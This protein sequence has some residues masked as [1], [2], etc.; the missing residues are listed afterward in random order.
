MWVL[1]PNGVT[2]SHT[3]VKSSRF[4]G[5]LS[6]M[7]MFPLG[8]AA[9][10]ATS[11]KHIMPSFPSPEIDWCRVLAAGLYCRSAGCS[12]AVTAAATRVTATAVSKPATGAASKADPAGPADLIRQLNL[13][14][15]QGQV[16]VQQWGDKQVLVHKATGRWI[17]RQGTRLV[18][19]PPQVKAMITCWAWLFKTFP[20]MQALGITS[21]NSSGSPPAAISSRTMEQLAEFDSILESKF[22]TETGFEGGTGVGGVVVVSGAGNTRQVIQLPTTPLKK[23]LLVGKEES[24]PGTPSPGPVKSPGPTLPSPTL[25]CPTSATAAAATN[26]PKPQEDPETMK[27]IQVVNYNSFVL[28]YTALHTGYS[29][30]LQ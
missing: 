18:T 1:L 30:R 4:T 10:T 14:R 19:V 27:R 11:N 12:T 26:F 15:A 9:T 23:E 29:G 16:V 7:R 28:H 6:A 5:Y 22:K 25:P 24:K 2:E 13:A 21:E 8:L 3:A 20:L 17:M